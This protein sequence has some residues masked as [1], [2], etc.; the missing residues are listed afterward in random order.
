MMVDQKYATYGK[1][2]REQAI[3]LIQIW[4]YE[5]HDREPVE[6]NDLEIM[7]K[8]CAAQYDTGW[9][10]KLMKYKGVRLG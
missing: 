9:R 6:I 5:N 4:N 1:P 2:T 8:R 3:R 10:T 7:V